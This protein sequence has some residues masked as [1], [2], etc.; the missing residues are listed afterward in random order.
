M[1][2]EPDYQKAYEYNKDL[3]IA[4]YSIGV[5]YDNM[6]KYKCVYKLLKKMATE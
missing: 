5:A 3:T 4:K 1:P 2:N 6:K